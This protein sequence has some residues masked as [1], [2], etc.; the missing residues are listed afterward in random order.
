MHASMPSHVSWK[1]A[2]LPGRLSRRFYLPC[3]T[4][5]PA[6]PRPAPPRPAL[7]VCMH[8]GQVN[9]VERGAIAIVGSIPQG[10]P[11]FT[12]GL[13]L[14]MTDPGFSDLFIPAII[15]TT[16]DLLKSTSIAR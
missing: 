15:I 16:V 3:L 8:A 4:L 5:R 6:P 12:G 2:C 9:S 1:N 11:G 13:W 10:L 7:F 14:P